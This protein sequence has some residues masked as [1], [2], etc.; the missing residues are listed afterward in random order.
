MKV[1]GE[2]EVEGVRRKGRAA[3]SVILAIKEGGR[4]EARDGYED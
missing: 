2:E 1:K 4:D 3:V